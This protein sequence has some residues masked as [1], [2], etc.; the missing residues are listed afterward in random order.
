MKKLALDLG[1]LLVESFETSMDQQLR[2]TVAAY[3][4]EM[5]CAAT[6]WDQGSCALVCDP[7][8]ITEGC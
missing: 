6:C 4:D 1:A 3:S 2:G 5:S 8:P 7:K